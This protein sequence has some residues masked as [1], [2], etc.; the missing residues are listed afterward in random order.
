M[1]ER[2]VSRRDVCET[3]Y[4]VFTDVYPG[5]ISKRLSFHTGEHSTENLLKATI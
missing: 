4:F 1:Q 3:P 5:V 2:E